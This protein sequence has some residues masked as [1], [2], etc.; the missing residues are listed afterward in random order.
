MLLHTLVGLIRRQFLSSS[1]IYHISQRTPHFHCSLPLSG[2]ELLSP[3]PL[4]HS[5]LGSL[6][7]LLGVSVT[8]SLSRSADLVI[9]TPPNLSG[10]TNQSSLFISYIQ[11]A[12]KASICIV[13]ASFFFLTVQKAVRRDR[14][15]PDRSHAG[16]YQTVRLRARSSPL[17]VNILS[18][19][20]LDRPKSRSTRPSSFRTVLDLHCLYIIF[21]PSKRPCD[22]AVRSLG[23]SR[24]PLSGRSSSVQISPLRP[25][26]FLFD[27][28]FRLFRRSASINSDCYTKIHWRVAGCLFG[29][30]FG[31]LSGYFWVRGVKI[32]ISKLPYY[33]LVFPFKEDLFKLQRIT[34][35]FV[36]RVVRGH[37][38]SFAPTQFHYSS[39]IYHIFQRSPTF[40]LQSPSITTTILQTS[41]VFFSSSFTVL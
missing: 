33:L 32:C 17:T 34:I 24:R 29:C 36:V 5:N 26:D 20:F 4:S 40:P 2:Y 15:F 35:C 21:R 11:I 13:F 8:P 7:P 23:R 12:S 30:L 3:K 19:L 38:A 27:R 25:F 18:I 31:C 6:N 16:R 41:I 39:R 37:V 22:K 14:P 1:R 9:S 10:L 28:H